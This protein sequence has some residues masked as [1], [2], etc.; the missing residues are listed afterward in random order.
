MG[1]FD[2]IS[3]AVSS[4]V[5]VIKKVADTVVAAFA[6]PSIETVATAGLTVA[7]V[8]GIGFLAYKI[9][10]KFIGW[11]NTR[12]SNHAEP[13]NILERSLKA[14]AERCEGNSDSNYDLNENKQHRTMKEVLAD[15]FANRRRNNIE[16]TEYDDSEFNEKIDKVMASVEA[17]TVDDIDDVDA[18]Y[19]ST[20]RK[21]SKDGKRYV[22]STYNG[23]YSRNYKY[24]LIHSTSVKDTSD[25]HLSRSLDRFGTARA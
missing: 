1:L 18:I 19:R 6:A 22:K 2:F 20:M 24:P 4:A 23:R 21:R 16:D 15:T 12:K 3:K 14:A 8:G 17:E 13:S 10:K 5:G 11:L 25:D 7:A 9:G